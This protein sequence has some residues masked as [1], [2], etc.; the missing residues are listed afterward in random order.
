MLTMRNR[1]YAQEVMTSQATR[2]AR[3]MRGYTEPALQRGSQAM[4]QG[5]RMVERLLNS[6]MVNQLLIRYGLRQPPSRRAMRRVA[7]RWPLILG[8]ASAAVIGAGA[9]LM[10]APRRG[11][12]TRRI[13]GGWL[14]RTFNRS[15]S[16]VSRSREPIMRTTK[17][18]WQR[19]R[20]GG[21]KVIRGTAQTASRV[22][23]MLPHNGVK[24]SRESERE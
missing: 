17:V 4:A 10:L 7:S 16:A 15:A 22:T 6:P 11:D 19:G 5:S 8:L 23:R 24:A 2:A 20:S 12:E 14:S 21:S 13:V 3:A 1:R 9:A 18:V